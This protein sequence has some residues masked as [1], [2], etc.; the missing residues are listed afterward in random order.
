MI[1]PVFVSTVTVSAGRPVMS[2]EAG[3]AFHQPS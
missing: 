3:V 1:S 2:P